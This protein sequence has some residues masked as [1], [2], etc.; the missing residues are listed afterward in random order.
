MKFLLT[1]R[2]GADLD[3][4]GRDVAAEG[5]TLTD[6]PPVPV[7]PADGG[8]ARSAAEELVVYAEGPAHLVEHLK[9]LSSVLQVYP[10]SDQEPYGSGLEPS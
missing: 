6:E 2:P 1:V 7:E 9:G 3:E 4:L 8:A 10:H 5:G